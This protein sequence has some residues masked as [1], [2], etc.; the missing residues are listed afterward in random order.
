MTCSTLLRKASTCLMYRVITS[1][2]REIP[3]VVNN[4]YLPEFYV[5][6]SI[7][8]EPIM[9]LLNQF[10]LVALGSLPDKCK[11]AFRN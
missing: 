4:I 6:E 1:C 9:I 5:A 10:A 3:H 2:Q 11:K 7:T 8:E